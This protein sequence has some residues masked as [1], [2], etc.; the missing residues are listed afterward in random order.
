MEKRNKNRFT[1]FLMKV[2][3]RKSFDSQIEFTGMDAHDLAEDRM[4]RSHF[5]DLSTYKCPKSVTHEILRMTVKQ[6]KR[7][8]RDLFDFPIRWKVGTGLAGAV[9]IVILALIFSSREKAVQPMQATV[10]E[11]EMQRAKDQL[12]WSLA[13]TSQ[14]LNQSEKKALHE[15]VMDELPKTLRNTL[16]KAVPIFKGGKS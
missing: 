16:E 10:T 13:Y 9:A 1:H 8:L 6:E 11:A 3:A 15:A 4:L 7:S 2:F 14:L 5:K 12:K